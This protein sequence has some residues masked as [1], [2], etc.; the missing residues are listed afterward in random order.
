LCFFLFFFVFWGGGGGGPPG[1]MVPSWRQQHYW[2]RQIWETDL[3][4]A[5]AP[6]VFLPRSLARSLLLLLLFFFFFCL[7]VLG[8]ALHVNGDRL[9]RSFVPNR[10]NRASRNTTT[11]HTHKTT[12][13]PGRKFGPLWH[14]K[15]LGG[16]MW[17]GS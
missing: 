6:P 4:M 5:R 16:H 9:D 10:P 15:F 8:F 12:T 11:R 1:W 2:W 3:A 7:F 14:G 17:M 13:R